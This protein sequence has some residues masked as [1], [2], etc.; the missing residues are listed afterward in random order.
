MKRLEFDEKNNLA[1]VLK[2]LQKEPE[3]EI[4]IYLFPGSEILKDS[5]NKEIIE[6][7]AKDLNKKVILK[8]EVSIKP[9][10]LEES[11]NEVKDEES[12]GFVEGKDVAED[13]IEDKAP[14]EKKKEGFSLPKL[15]KLKFL[16]GPKWIYFLIGFLGFIVVGGVLT[17]WLVP[18]ATVT[19]IT[20][21][22]FKESELAIVASSKEEEVDV[23][24]GIIPLKTLETTVE[25]VLEVK[26]TGSK[27]VGT[28]AKGRVKIV[29]RDTGNAKTYFK[30]TT[31]T[32][33]SGT[34]ISFSL[35]AQAT[36]SAAPAGCEAD[37]PQAGVDVTAKS[38]GDSG[39]LKAGT[40]FKIGSADVNLVFAKSDT[41]FSGGSS[42]KIK[43]VSANDQKKVKEDLLEKLET[44]AK[45]ELEAENPKIVIPG[46]G[47]EAEVINE[48]Y[49]K[50]IGEE[51]ADFRL[52]L[53]V[54]FSAKVF[55][56]DDL[57]NILINSIS[58]SI[59]SGFK[60]DK[61][62]SSVESEILEK[63][64]DDLKVLG[65]IKANLIPIIDTS[66]IAKNIAGKDFGATDKYLKSIDAITAFEI[67]LE[68]TI[69]KLFGTMPFVSSR[70]K[71]DV[72]VEE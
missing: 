50:K 1:D 18:K 66:D 54:K 32:S 30:G 63:G 22:K 53:E 56:E 4:E 72:T 2:A 46:G 3:N 35:D 41:N 52:S 40:V 67:K 59:P 44:K 24:K 57:K 60:I 47:L 48:T 49:S 27:T 34:A 55:S 58:K 38:I 14:V 61:E 19:L 45:E 39:N 5:A 26:S 33:V 37:C 51:A 69:M 43:I 31:I 20:E 25:D 29:N 13:Q 10:I 42:K 15:P 6:L 71:V 28:S 16:K 65:K 12:H 36:V 7:L 64:D 8:G 68:P 11:K 9:A 21:Q 17:F 70:I 23:D 62:G